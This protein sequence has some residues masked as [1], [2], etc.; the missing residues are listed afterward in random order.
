M[1]V[2]LENV[3]YIIIV[4]W[5]LFYIL[6]SL[7]TIGDGLP[8]SSC[9]KGRECC[10]FPYT[11]LESLNFYGNIYSLVGSWANGSCFD[12]EAGVPFKQSDAYLKHNLHIND[13]QTPVEAYWK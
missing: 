10:L 12:P 5:T 1:M 6:N 3:Y 8:W 11:V 2:F 4:A 7:Y 13:T 9:E